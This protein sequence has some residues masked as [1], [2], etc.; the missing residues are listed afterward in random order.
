MA[1]LWDAA[2]F[3]RVIIALHIQR[4]AVVEVE[5]GAAVAEA[6]VVRI[7]IIKEMNIFVP[8]IQGLAGYPLRQ[9]LL[10]HL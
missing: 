3:P 4:P 10:A 8:A 5:M 7:Q 6:M 2:L 1:V 9:A